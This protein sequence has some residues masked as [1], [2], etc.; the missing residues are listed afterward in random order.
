[1][2]STSLPRL[3]VL[4][5]GLNIDGTDIGEALFAHKWADCISREVDLTL[6]CLQRPGRMPVA[7]Q[8]PYAR[9]IT[10]DEPAF[11]ARFERVRAMLKPA[12][13]L[14]CIKVRHWIKDAAARGERFDIAHQLV[15]QPLRHATPLRNQGMPYVIGPKG[16]SL[17]TPPAFRHELEPRS[18]F[19]RLRDLDHVRLAVDPTLRRTYSD[20]DLVIGSAPYIREILGDIPLKR[21]E[22]IPEFAGEKPYPPVPHKRAAGTLRLLHVG[23]GVRTKGLR[24]VVRALAK[25]PDLPDITLTSAGGGEEI[26]LCE[27]EAERLGVQNRVRFLGQVPR[28]E[29]ENLY[30]QS[31]LLAFP[32]F[33]EPM[34]GVF[35]EAMRWGLP[36]IA[37]DRGGPQVV[38]DESCG[39]RIPVTDPDRFSSDIADAIRS[40]AL[41][42]QRLDVLSEGAR[43]KLVGFGSWG[44]RG[45]RMAALYREII[46]ARS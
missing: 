19:V 33:R 16:G 26:R 9:V 39:I 46:E 42:P 41:D 35:F 30:A 11:L 25:L 23:R 22:V 27:Q 36:A 7:E 13:P 5:I 12:W 43:K 21:F 38:I 31:D 28:A 40:L 45:V 4:M 24:D 34:G 10:W 29:V 32:S 37:A 6:L 3:K 17:D 15:P 8:L 14:F 1:M 20:A 18:L 44:D 2:P